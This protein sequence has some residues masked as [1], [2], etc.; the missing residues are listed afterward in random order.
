MKPRHARRHRKYH[1][2]NLQ[3]NTKPN[4]HFKVHEQPHSNLSTSLK[5]QRSPIGLGIPT[6][7]TSSVPLQTSQ[8]D[9]QSMQDMI[10]KYLT[11]TTKFN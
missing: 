1:V 9:S 11:Q 7:S 4:I 5:A 2:K 10:S 6:A 3:N 8:T